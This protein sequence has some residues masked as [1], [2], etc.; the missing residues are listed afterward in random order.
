MNYLRE[1]V[2]SKLK[3][4]EDANTKEELEDLKKYKLIEELLKDDACFFKIDSNIAYSILLEL[5]IPNPL[6]YYKNLISY[7]EFKKN[8]E[9][10]DL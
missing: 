1:L 4:L 2:T 3:T 8:K 6:D 5:K 10:F 7:K 9:N